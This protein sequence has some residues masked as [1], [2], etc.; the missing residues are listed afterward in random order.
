MSLR[1]KEIHRFVYLPLSSKLD[2]GKWLMEESQD[3]ERGTLDQFPPGPGF[4][5]SRRDCGA[6]SHLG[7][8]RTVLLLRTMPVGATASRILVGGG[9]GWRQKGRTQLTTV[10]GGCGRWCQ[11]GFWQ[12]WGFLDFL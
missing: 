11:V 12:N 10:A 7:C 4:A 9:G 2:S 3:K 6:P 5:K 8:V 1:R